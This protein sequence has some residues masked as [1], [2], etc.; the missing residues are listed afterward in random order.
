MSIVRYE[1][2]DGYLWI[3]ADWIPPMATVRQRPP[4]RGSK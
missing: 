2:R 3:F 1:L 4:V